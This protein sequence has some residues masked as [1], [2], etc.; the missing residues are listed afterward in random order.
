MG[1]EVPRLSI[2]YSKVVLSPEDGVFAIAF[3]VFFLLFAY[4]AWTKG[5]RKRG[6]GEVHLKQTF[7]RA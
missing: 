1:R 2:D 6:L 7:A 5:K 3:L 4:K